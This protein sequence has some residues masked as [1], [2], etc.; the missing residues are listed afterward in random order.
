MVLPDILPL[1]HWYHPIVVLPSIQGFILD[2]GPEFFMRCNIKILGTDIGCVICSADKSD[3][4]L[5]LLPS[6]SNEMMT[7]INVFHP[8]AH[9]LILDKSNCTLVVV[10]Q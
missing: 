2:V 4:G 8:L 5:V 10:K 6:V 7:D 1:R 9:L 3:N